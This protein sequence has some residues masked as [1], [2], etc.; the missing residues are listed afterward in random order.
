MKTQDFFFNLPE[1]LIA[2]EPLVGQ[3]E[4]ARGNDRLMVLRRR[5]RSVEHKTVD[6]LPELL[7]PGTLLVLNNS[8]VRKARIYGRSWGPDRE[9][10]TATEFL[11]IKRTAE[12]GREQEREWEALCKKRKRI[13]PGSVFTFPADRGATPETAIEAEITGHTEDG[14]TLR[15]S[16]NIDDDYLDAYGH[17]PLPPYIKRQ[18]TALDAERY[19]N[20]YAKPHGSIASPTA[21]L[22]LTEALLSKIRER[23]IETA[24][25]TLHVGLGTFLP[26]RAE[27]VEDHRMHEEHYTIDDACA[28]RINRALGEKRP[29]TAV[30]TTSLRCLESACLNGRIQPGNRTSGMFIYPG[31]KFKA[32]DSLFTNF[33]TPCSTLLMLVCALAGKD[34]IMEAYRTAIAEQYRFFSYGDAMLIS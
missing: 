19:Q 10:N 13:K 31:Y 11:L 32:V 5:T 16:R 4:D 1:A 33:H 30:G 24:F 12:G 29:I 25:V 15:F 18:D 17:I 20:V 7:P 9:T 26:V 2:Q 21:G 27:R 6:D 34:F 3:G 14:V 28:E 8:R 23:G 22:H